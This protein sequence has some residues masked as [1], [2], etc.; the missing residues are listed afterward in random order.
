MI[1][2][3]DVMKKLLIILICLLF[4]INVF[5][6]N[7]EIKSKS[8]IVV[9]R[10]TD[11]ILYEKEKDLKLPIA[12]LTKIMTVMISLENI[13]S[14]SDT[15]VV[16][17]NDISN[18]LGYQVIGLTNGIE[19]SYKDL[20]YSTLLYSAADSAKVLSNNVFNKYDDFINKM[21]ELA[22]MIGMENTN[23]SN[24]IGFDK[25]NYSSS[26]DLYKLL[27]YAL[28]NETFYDIFTT[29]NYKMEGLDKSIN[30]NLNSMID[31]NNLKRNNISFDGFKGGYTK[32]SGLSLG[33]ITKIDG[34][35]L[36]IVTIGAMGEIDS[37]KNIIDA[38]NILSNIKDNYSNRVILANDKLVDNIIYK[39]G[40]KEISYEIRSPKTLNYYMNNSLDLNYLKIFYEGTTII[41]EDVKEGDKLGK[42]S[43]YYE[44]KLLDSVDIKFN[45]KYLVKDSKNYK[46]IL[47]FVC[48]CL[49]GLIVF[50]KR[51]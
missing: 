11:E 22:N 34:N 35:E 7:F 5:A 51:K 24:P 29:K 37:K 49:L 8:A 19:V 3:I 10:E 39:D 2:S 1:I 33:A 20:I 9:N 30:N 46:N 31:S 40:E 23:F 36:I 41:N 27:E 32:T 50:R 43:V 12:S 28:D 38:L 14:L 16:N 42:V 26:Y 44:D 21:N 4:P 13:N 15:V 48:I 18:L 45:K 47:I 6:S 25:D 17:S